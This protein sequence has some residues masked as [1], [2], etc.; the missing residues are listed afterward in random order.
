MNHV[1]GAEFLVPTVSLWWRE[2]VRFARQ[3]SRIVGALGT[4]V[5]F[6]LLIG[7]GLGRS[8]SI[9]SMGA[10]GP[11]VNYLEYFFPGTMV[12]IVLFTAIF[13][14]I[15]LIEDRRAGFLQAVIASPARRAAIV[16]GKVLGS[17]TL[18]VTQALLFLLF[19]P[20]AGVPLTIRGIMALIAVLVLLGFG[21]SGLGFL[22]AWPMD[23]TQGFHAIM[24]LFLIPM[25]LLSGALFP[26][27]GASTW[28]GW[29]MALNPLTYGVALVRR[30]LDEGGLADAAGT[31][32][33]AV[34]LIVVTIFALLMVMLCAGAVARRPPV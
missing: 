34:S 31:P 13:S 23:S 15:S 18:A 22:I 12:L 7:S 2:I 1:H 11:P 8:F 25:W 19:A 17:T 20:L 5:V 33:A 28:L 4:P 6:W 9:D 29:V 32:S 26:S 10:S 27:S 14:T 21:L 24:N 16:L 3:R 30:A